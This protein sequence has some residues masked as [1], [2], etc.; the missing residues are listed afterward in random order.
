[1]HKT[2]VFTGRLSWLGI[3]NRI[4]MV[5]YNKAVHVDM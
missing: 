3:R 1:M 4:K 2:V 5:H